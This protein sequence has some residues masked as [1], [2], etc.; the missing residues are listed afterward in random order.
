M[1]RAHVDWEGD[2]VCGEERQTSRLHSSPP[3]QPA[4]VSARQPQVPTLV[5]PTAASCC[6]AE[7]ITAHP[8]NNVTESIFQKIGVN[9]HQQPNHPLGILKARGGG[10]GA[11]GGRWS[12][13]AIVHGCG[14]AAA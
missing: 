5:R 12:V 8:Y 13:G 11:S 14:A 7:V 1:V 4:A 2:A 6:L 9:L 3:G 10:G